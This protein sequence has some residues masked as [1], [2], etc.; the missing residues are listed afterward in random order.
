MQS[1]ANAATGF[2]MLRYAGVSVMNVLIGQS[3]LYVFYAQMDISSG[4]AN[5]ASVLLS[6]IPAFLFSKRWVWKQEDN[7]LFGHDA[8]VFFTMTAIGLVA[9]TLA[10]IVATRFSN[11]DLAPN[12]AN[13]AAFGVVWVAKFVV[14]ER[15]I[16][17]T[18]DPAPGGESALLEPVGVGVD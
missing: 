4:R 10:V 5:V 18:A 16:W 14:L 13:L 1:M 11:A 9:S 8:V 6:M 3:L 2:R 15:L 7:G 17:P 12:V